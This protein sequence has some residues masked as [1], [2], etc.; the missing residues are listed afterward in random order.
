MAA[1]AGGKDGFRVGQDE[2]H[3]RRGDRIAARNMVLS[4]VD[5]SAFDYPELTPLIRCCLSG[6]SRSNSKRNVQK[7]PNQTRPVC[8]ASRRVVPAVLARIALK[9]ESN[10]RRG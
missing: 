9:D 7:I 10:V 8:H 1:P 5:T 6:G 4:L 2:S 3:C